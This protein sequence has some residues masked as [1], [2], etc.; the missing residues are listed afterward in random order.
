MKIL[1]IQPAKSPRTIG[2]EDI[3]LFEPLSLEYVGA[4]VVDDHDVRLLDLRLEGDL[5]GVLEAFQPTVAGITALTVHLPATREL[6]RRIKAWNP[7]SVVVVGGHHATVAPDDLMDPHIDLV[8][9]GE[10]IGPFRELVRRIEAGEG[11]D[12]LPGVYRPVAGR[13]QGTPPDPHVPLDELPLPARSLTEAHRGQFF[14]QWMRPM[15]AIITSMGCPYRCSYCAIWKLT[16]GKRLTRSP[17]RILEEI[18]G[19]DEDWVFFADYESLI[20]VERMDRLADLLAEAGVEKRYCLYGRSDTIV[21]HPDLMRKWRDVGLDTV[22]VGFEFFRD[23]DLDEVHKGTT[24][25][26]NEGAIEVLDALGI[27][28]GAYFL[29]KPEYDR[30]DFDELRAY[31]RGLDLS[32][33]SFFV[34]TPLPGTDFHD[35]RCNDLIATDPEL[36]DFFHTL[37]PTTLP[38]DEFYDQIY[39]CYRAPLSLLDA[40][41]LLWNFPLLDIPGGML[42]MQRMLRRVRRAH[43]DHD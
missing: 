10:G 35:E 24:T 25:A 28:I 5:E 19:L 36:F 2:G 21:H 7:S 29:V 14:S 38:L 3:H 30:D 11:L 20:D 37:L 4:G 6:A 26:D 33:A 1:L 15:A 18:Q 32:F 22:I 16:D 43:L 27:H 12:D 13:L 42:R 9:Q 31:V 34:M 23:S 41:S 40:L 17:E 8:V 39:R